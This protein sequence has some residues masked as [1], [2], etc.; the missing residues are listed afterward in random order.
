MYFDFFFFYFI[1]YSEGICAVYAT[2]SHH[3]QVKL[4]FPKKMCVSCGICRSP[5][6]FRMLETFALTLLL[7]AYSFCS[8]VIKVVSA[9]NI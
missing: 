1:L 7:C 9:S 3:I 8:I 2:F 6:K 5:E 4:L